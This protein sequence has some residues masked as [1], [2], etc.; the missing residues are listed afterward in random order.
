M[1]KV[2][3]VIAG[4]LAWRLRHMSHRHFVLILSAI[5]GLIV[6]ASAVLVKLVVH[7]LYFFINDLK[8]HT[9]WVFVFILPLIGILLTNL[10]AIRFFK[11]KL[12]H[13]VT[14]VLFNIAKGSSNLKKRLSISRVI[15]SAISVGFGGSV[16][17][18]APLIITG[19]AVGSNLAQMMRLHYKSRT[20]L[21]GCGSAAAVAGIFNS[22]I[23]G[24]IFAIEVILAEITIDKFIPILIASVCGSLVPLIFQQ[25]EVLFNFTLQDNFNAVDLP[26]YMALGAISG[27]VALYF[28]RTHYFL[29]AKLGAI[30]D[31]RVRILLGGTALAFI[32]FLFP[33]MYG[34]GYEIIKA[35]IKGNEVILEKN[36]LLFKGIDPTFTISFIV[37]SMVIVKAIASACTIGAGGSGGIFAPS[38]FVGGLTGFLFSRTANILGS[39][40]QVSTSNFT[41]VGMCGVLSAVLH[42][43]LTGIFLI[44]EIT[45]GYTLFIPL[46]IVSAIAYTTISIFEPHSIYTKHLIEKGDLIQGNKD[47]EL[48]SL[49]KTKRLINKEYPS[50]HPEDTLGALVDIIKGTSTS[51]IPVLDHDGILQGLINLEDIKNIIFDKEKYYIVQVKTI[52]RPASTVVHMEDSPHSIMSLFEKTHKWFLPVVENDNR[53]FIGFIDREKLFNAYRERLI[54]QDQQDL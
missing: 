23:T 52:M 47:K 46:M 24:V 1:H 28:T 32:I 26:L 13:G 7:E 30:K 42:A 49:I 39:S 44:A 33:A 3:H 19:S 15:T 27:L 4:I 5:L 40:D 16:G 9:H 17:L 31:N 43:P 45:G 8:N 41:L 11:E 25:N 21:I 20:L 12:G 34:E 14:S 48:L 37:L 36:N 2:Q 10:V 54:K 38:L 51:N 50:V 22:P 6:G 18:E 35:L 53:K 29:E